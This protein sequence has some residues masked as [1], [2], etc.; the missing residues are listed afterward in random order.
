MKITLDFLFSDPHFNHANAPG[1]RNFDGTV[2]EMNEIIIDRWNAVVS[3][4]DR[5]GL[6]GDSIM[7]PRL[8]GL[9]LLDNLNGDILLWP[10]N[11]DHSW[12]GNSR[13]ITETN[14]W[15]ELY[16]KYVTHMEDGVYEIEGLPAP[17]HVSHFPYY[18]DHTEEDRYVE[19]RPIDDG[20]W[21][22]HGHVHELWAVN[23]RMINVGFDAWGEPIPVAEVAKI[24]ERRLGF[25]RGL[26]T[27]LESE[28]Q[29]SKS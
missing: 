3:S 28:P 8:K 14:N 7:G 15:P 13:R 9:P 6:L 19:Y 11:H 18:G 2:E 12:I 10:G 1:H 24:M 22:L 23:G 26:A 20:L 4:G 21:L 25:K 29:F 27:P 17:V 5:V 16:S